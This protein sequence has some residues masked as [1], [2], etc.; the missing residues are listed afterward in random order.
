MPQQF[1]YN[2][3]FK[4]WLKI[5][6]ICAPITFALSKVTYETFPGG[7]QRGRH[8]NV[9]ATFL[10]D[11]PPPKIWEGKKTSKIRRDV[12]KLPNFDREYLQNVSRY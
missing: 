1:L 3:K 5:K 10:K 11:K 4:H 6:R 9:G 8:D 12:L 7:V 2:D